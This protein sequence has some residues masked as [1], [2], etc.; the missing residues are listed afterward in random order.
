MISYKL[1][2]SACKI[3]KIDVI[4]CEYQVWQFIGSAC[5]IAFSGREN[6]LN[7]PFFFFSGLPYSETT[8]AEGLKE[9][10]YSTAIVGKWHLVRNNI[11]YSMTIL[12]RYF[13]A[14]TL[15]HSGLPFQ[16]PCMK[17]VKRKC[18]HW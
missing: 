9:K 11:Y 17:A 2:R 12:Y 18:E 1:I 14:M 8:M 4:L 10:G 16:P 3:A 6:C 15:A 7:A 13:L 5:K